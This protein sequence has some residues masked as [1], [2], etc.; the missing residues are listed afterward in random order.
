[1]D[2]V[3]VVKLGVTLFSGAQGEILSADLGRGDS[4]FRV[5]VWVYLDVFGEIVLGEIGLG[6]VSFTSL[7]GI[8][9]RVT[10]MSISSSSWT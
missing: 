9:K 5:E 10:S 1:M 8:R 2:L 4:V 3:E 6:K 7:K